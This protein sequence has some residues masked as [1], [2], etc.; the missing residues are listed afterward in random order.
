MKN[1]AIILLII[2]AGVIAALYLMGYFQFGNEPEELNTEGF[3]IT[4]NDESAELMIPKD[5]LPDNVDLDD[6]SVTRVSNKLSENGTW[7]VYDLEPDGLVFKEEILFNVTLEGVSNALP[8]VFISNGAG[9]ELVNNTFTEVDLGNNTQIVS[10]PLTHFSTI[11]I[12]PN[13]GTFN[14]ELS[15]PDVF[16]DDTVNTIASFTLI[17]SKLLRDATATGQGIYVYE[18]LEPYVTYKGTWISLAGHFSLFTPDGEFGGKPS[19]TQVGL[20]QTNTV[21]DDT[22]KSDKIGMSTL[23]YKAEVTVGYKFTH[24]ASESDYLKGNASFSATY[25]NQKIE[26]VSEVWIEVTRPR[27]HI[28]GLFLTQYENKLEYDLRVETVG[29]DSKTGIVTLT[30][31]G[32]EPIKQPLVLNSNGGAWNTF[33]LTFRGEITVLVEVGDLTAERK[34]VV[35]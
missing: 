17:K 34:I 27:L 16:I 19:S 30:G 31:I 33:I 13:T 23:S 15:A 1:K 9:I 26:I 6:I 14:I 5:A 8:L 18:F 21:L 12:L 4:S 35:D 22:F 25:R 2:V 3:P 32:M 20:G 24:Y 29:P 11:H 10:I 7:V 28:Q